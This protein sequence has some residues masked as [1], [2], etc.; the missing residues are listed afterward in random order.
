M[1]MKNGIEYFFDWF[2]RFEVITVLLWKSPFSFQIWTWKWDRVSENE[3]VSLFVLYNLV[4]K[5]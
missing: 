1:L 3:M 5:Q 2:Y 4:A